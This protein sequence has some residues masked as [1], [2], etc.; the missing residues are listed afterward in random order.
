MYVTT[1]ITIGGWWTAYY[2]PSGLMEKPKDTYEYE[3]FIIDD[4][5]LFIEKKTFE[6]YIRKNELLIS[7]EGYGR[8]W[9]YI[10]EE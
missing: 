4:V 10:D 6:E 7:V 2:A 3:E 9:L 5:K 8:Y 1:R